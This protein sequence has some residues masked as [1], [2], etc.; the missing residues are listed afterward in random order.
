MRIS[1]WSSDVCSSVLLLAARAGD[2]EQAVDLALVEHAGRAAGAVGRRGIVLGRAFL[3]HR[4]PLR[5]HR[6]FVGHVSQ[7]S[8]DRKYL[9]GSAAAALLDQQDRKS[10]RLNSSH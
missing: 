9:P 6:F 10:T 3:G 4:L 2:A 5:H 7:K 8:Y 1:D